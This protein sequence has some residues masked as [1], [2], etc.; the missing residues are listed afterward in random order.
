VARMPRL[1]DQTRPMRSA[2]NKRAGGKGG[3]AAL[4][5]ALLVRPA[6]ARTL[7]AMFESIR[8]MFCE[9]TLG[10]RLAQSAHP[11]FGDK[12]RQLISC[13]LEA[14]NKIQRICRV[15]GDRFLG[16]EKGT[17]LLGGR[18]SP[19]IDD[20]EFRLARASTFSEGGRVLANARR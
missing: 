9:W 1:E 14:I 17:G 5:C 12:H 4:F 11:E 13:Q 7:E 16:D 6:S 8:T 19:A 2:S 10:G 20:R 15:D 3:F 18:G